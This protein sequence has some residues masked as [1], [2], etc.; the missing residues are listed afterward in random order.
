MQDLLHK[1]K[2]G[3]WYRM[4]ICRVFGPLDDEDAFWQ[5]QDHDAFLLRFHR[6]TLKS[7]QE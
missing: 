1:E 7:G 3:S 4:K 5:L 6:R 2:Q